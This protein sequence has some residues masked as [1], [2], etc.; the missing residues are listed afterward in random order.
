MSCTTLSRSGQKVDSLKCVE[1]ER[2]VVKAMALVVVE[3]GEA[4]W[5]F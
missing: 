5:F 3:G 2:V 1:I 4:I